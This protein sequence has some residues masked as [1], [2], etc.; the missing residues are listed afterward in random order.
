M[1]QIEETYRPGL[2]HRIDK[3]TEA[4]FMVITKNNDVHQRLAQQ[5]SENKMNPNG[6]TSPLLMVICRNGV[7]EAAHE[8]RTKTRCA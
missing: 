6:I 2:V 5:I 7:I 1:V 8:K 4:G 3:D